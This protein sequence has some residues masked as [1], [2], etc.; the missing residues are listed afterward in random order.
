MRAV[1][2]YADITFEPLYEYPGLDVAPEHPAVTFVKRL[3][4]RNDHAKV[5]YGTEAGLFQNRAGVASIV[6]GPGSI[7][8][9]HK[10]DEYLDLTQVELCERFMRRLLDRME[11]GEPATAGM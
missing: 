9:A 5:A 1:A 4:D 2:P 8:Q 6:C 3:V 7:E 10:P 11:Q